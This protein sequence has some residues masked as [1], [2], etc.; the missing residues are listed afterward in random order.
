MR[1][2]MFAAVITASVGLGA[3]ARI[4]TQ[5][6]AQMGQNYAQQI[7]A[8]LPII[9]DAE[10]NAYI[11]RLGDSLAVL[12][13][14]QGR[15]WQFFLVDDPEVNAF[16]VP[17]GYI[18]VNKGLVL[19]AQTLSQLAGVVGHEIAHVTQR[20][21]VQQMEKQQGIGI[22][23]TLVCIWQPSFC[24]QGGGD[25]LNLGATAAMAKFS[26]NDETEADR[27][28]LKYI[29]RAGLDPNGM[30]EM[31]EILLAERRSRGG[32]GGGFLAS[33]PMEE[34]RIR[35]TRAMIQQLPPDQRSGTRDSEAF[36]R[37]KARLA[38]LPPTPRPR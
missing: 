28:G 12:V 21:S 37:F 10:A 22:G 27:E 13:D 32:G 2:K 25:L 34:D 6:E 30:P 14:T 24:Q 16:A 15:N 31:F 4:S 38:A 9:R 1:V 3:C 26:R 23:A 20:H 17:G 19:R 11:N 8:Q 29:V 18:Y 36:Q 33:H 35:N 7:N 5:Q